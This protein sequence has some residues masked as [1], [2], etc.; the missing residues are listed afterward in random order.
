MTSSY[1]RDLFTASAPRRPYCAD[2]LGQGVRIRSQA[3]ALA[4]RYIQHNPP[5]ALAFLVFDFD[6]EG[7]LVAHQ[8][9]G[10][11]EPS[12]CAESRDT[13]RGHLAYAL[14]CPII[15]SDAAR[16]APV[17]YAAAVQQAYTDALRADPGYAN[18]LTKTP[19]HEDWHTRWGR[20][21]PFNLEELADYLP[22]GLP[23]IKQIRATP[24]HDASGLLR[25]VCLFEDLRKW[26]YRARLRFDDPDPW[27][28]ACHRHALGINGGFPNPLPANE[29][30][31]TA[32]SVAKWV[33]QRFN[34]AGFSE[35]QRQRAKRL[36]VAR[37]ASAM[38]TTQRLLELNR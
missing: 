20:A 34:A 5:Q 35:V 7:A 29:V 10:L 13:R 32:K 18:F 1:Q 8:D 12:W 23:A 30:K 31:A 4:H 37:Q 11:P 36:A 2:D 9:A 26:S 3:Q 17:R 38:D 24:R 33:W 16:A 6:G 25:N 21:E 19:G 27:H 22:H 28:D 15:T 14:A